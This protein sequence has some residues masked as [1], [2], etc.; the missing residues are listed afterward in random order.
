MSLQ[1]FKRQKF[2]WTRVRPLDRRGVAVLLLALASFAAATPASA[3]IYSWRDANGNLFLSDRKP[4]GELPIRT[5]AVP[6]A[7]AVRATK[8][9]A[10]D[11]T[12]AYDDLIAEHARLN[13]VR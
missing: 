9:V 5:Y 4:G 3:Q 10:A 2:V 13:G 1:P 6:G 7:T 8:Y 11:R 12:R